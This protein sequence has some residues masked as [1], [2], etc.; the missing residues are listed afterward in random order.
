[1]VS[2]NQCTLV[3]LLSLFRDRKINVVSLPCTV[4]EVVLQSSSFWQTD[5]RQ[6]GEGHESGEGTQGA[7]SRS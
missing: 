2:I 5:R 7:D 4:I 3:E 6:G 1:M